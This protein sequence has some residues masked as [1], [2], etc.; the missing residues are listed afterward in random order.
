M[1]RNKSQPLISILERLHPYG[2]RFGAC[3]SVYFILKMSRNTLNRAEY[4]LLMPFFQLAMLLSVLPLFFFVLRAVLANKYRFSLKD[5][6]SL[7]SFISIYLMFFRLEIL[8]RLEEVDFSDVVS[9]YVMTSL[10]YGVSELIACVRNFVFPLKRISSRNIE[11]RFLPLRW[12]WRDHFFCLLFGMMAY[13]AFALRCK[14]KL[15]EYPPCSLAITFLFIQ[16]MV[17]RYAIENSKVDLHPEG[18]VI[19]SRLRKWSQTRFWLERRLWWRSLRQMSNQIHMRFLWW[20]FCP[21][22]PSDKVEELQCLIDN[23]QQPDPL[24]QSLE[25]LH[26]AIDELERLSEEYKESTEQK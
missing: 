18:I 24:S 11:I 10:I 5:V 17:H 21:S 13:Y 26:N 9:G 23:N 12:V 1:A 25:E 2:W 16:T 4:D 8:N 6:L 14:D 22:I 20:S 19:D 7:M 3:L 15:G